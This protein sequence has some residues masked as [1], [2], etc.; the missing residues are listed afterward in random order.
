MKKNVDLNYLLDELDKKTARQ[1]FKKYIK[2]NDLISNSKIVNKVTMSM[3]ELI[4]RTAKEKDKRL[5]RKDLLK[6]LS[7]DL[8][9]K[10]VKK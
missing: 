2:E 4:W 3:F 9:M 6:I 10:E 5:S 1:V 8:F 7:E